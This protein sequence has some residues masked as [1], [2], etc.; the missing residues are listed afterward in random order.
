MALTPEIMD[1]EADELAS[2]VLEIIEALTT[3]GQSASQ[4]IPII[5]G[6]G[7]STYGDAQAGI[8]EDANKRRFILQVLGKGIDRFAQTMPLTDEGEG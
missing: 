6:K 1:A 5:V 8:D 2:D 3:P 4:L 7:L